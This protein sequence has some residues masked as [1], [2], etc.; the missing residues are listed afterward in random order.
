MKAILYFFM[1]LLVSISLKAQD[2][3]FTNSETPATNP[4]DGPIEIGTVIRPAVNG[5]VTHFRFWKSVKNDASTFTLNARAMNGQV[6][7]SQTFKAQGQNGWLRVPITPALNVTGGTDYLFSYH[8]PSGRHGQ[9]QNVFTSSRTRG[10]LMAPASP[11]NGRYKSGEVSVFPD[12]TANAENYFVDIVFRKAAATPLIVNAG[13]DTTVA[14]PS[15]S[16]RLYGKITGD[17]YTFKWTEMMDPALTSTQLN[18]VF[19]GLGLQEYNFVLTATRGSEVVTDTVRV[20]VIQAAA[21]LLSDGTWFIPKG[22]ILVTPY[23]GG[24]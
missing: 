16:V 19:K 21:I 22:S 2:S 15:D 14:F 5:Q 9:R 11:V 6:L 4:N 8:S 3:L 1:A 7:W 13:K 24:K 10:N 12:E 23:P 18:P 17:G 20:T